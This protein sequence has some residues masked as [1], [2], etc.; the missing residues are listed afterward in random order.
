MPYTIRNAIDEVRHEIG[1]RSDQRLTE[2]DIVN[3]AGE[4]LYAMRGWK[5]LQRY[6]E[7]PTVQNAEVLDL[8]VDVGELLA[9]QFRERVVRAMQQTSMSAIMDARALI[10]PPLSGTHLWTLTNID[11][12]DAA[13]DPRPQIIIFP[14][15]P[16]TDPRGIALHYRAAWVPM[17]AGGRDDQ[18]LCGTGGR[19]PDWMGNMLSAAIR[20][21]A[22]GLERSS[23]G[24]LDARLSSLGRG[25]LFEAALRRDVRLQRVRG[26]WGSPFAWTSGRWQEGAALPPG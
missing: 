4:H 15:F 26:N 12:V 21:F 16:S 20:A 19:M 18:V 7:L 24:S 22:G 10:T 17:R 25:P 9:V 14:G 2:L 1:G 6:V 5:A 8:P 11:A 3:R 13:G 23:Q